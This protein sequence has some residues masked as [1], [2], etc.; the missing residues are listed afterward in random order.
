MAAPAAPA[1]YD[2]VREIGSGGFGTV[3]LARSQTGIWRAV[4]I[5]ASPSPADREVFR[6]ELSGITRFQAA[7]LGLSASAYDAT[8]NSKYFILAGQSHVMLGNL[9]TLAAPS[10][11][12]SLL[13]WTTQWVNGDASWAS[14]K[15]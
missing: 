9:L 8:A 2:L 5:V 4:K 7:T 1:G 6:R 14:V 12:P 15:P 3:W 13:T 11:G 10:P